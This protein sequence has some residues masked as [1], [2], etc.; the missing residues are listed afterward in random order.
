[1]LPISLTGKKPPE[2]I[3]VIEILKES[4][5]L[6]LINFNEINIKKVKAVYKIKIL[7]DCLNASE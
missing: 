1:M 6:R 7:N 4:K 3:M 5:V 2:E